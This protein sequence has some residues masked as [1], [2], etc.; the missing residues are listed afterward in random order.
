[1]FIAK[2]KHWAISLLLASLPVQAEPAQGPELGRPATASEIIAWDIDIAPDG[3]GLPSGQGTV[4]AGEALYDARCAICHGPQGSGG[5]ADA[6]AGAE[7]PLSGEWPDKTIGSYWP[8]ATTLF[9]F[10]RRAMPLDAPGSL[11]ADDV[12]ALTG[13]LLYL[14]GIIDESEI[15]NA[16]TLRKIIMPN[17]DGFL[18]Q[19]PEPAQ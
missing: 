7:G 18:V 11:N 14:N 9:D 12:Y 5:S 16:D 4:T 19:Y 1:M 8:Y 3:A 10:I 15:M 17:R 6:L 13:Y 2:P